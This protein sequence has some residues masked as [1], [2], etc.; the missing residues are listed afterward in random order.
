MNNIFDI[1]RFGS[2]LMYDLRNLKSNYLLSMLI[3]GLMPV[4]HF[5]IQYVTAFVF[6]GTVPDYVSA[7]VPAIAFG[8]F[9]ALVLTMPAKLYGGITE[10][11]FGSSW[12]MIP[13]STLE[14]WLSLVLMVCVIVPLGTA[15]AFLASDAALSALV[16]SYGESFLS[17]LLE[18]PRGMEEE[19]DGIMNINL[20]GIGYV[21][22]VINVLFFTLGALFFKRNKAAK[23]ILC[24]FALFMLLM[25][26]MVVVVRNGWSPEGLFG[27]AE[28]SVD[29]IEGAVSK[30]NLIVN[31]ALVL[32]CGLELAGIYWL[33]HRTQH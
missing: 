30:I 24:G 17:T 19:M 10:R 11:R 18:L 15:V 26:S 14:K 32:V 9:I 20:F 6:N 8:A 29:F 3:I 22:W 2:Y 16:P 28:M 4:I 1:K 27:T 25:I 33:L 7:F 21:G 31:V 12:L 23:T 13:A 5:L